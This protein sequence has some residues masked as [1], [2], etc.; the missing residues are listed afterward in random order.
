MDPD[1]HIY[2]RNPGASGI[3]T[4]IAWALPA[5][6]QPGSIHW[7]P[8]E[9]Y[10][11]GDLITYVYHD[12]VMLLVPL[13]LAKDLSPGRV[14]LRAR[15]SWLECKESCLPGS[16]ELA[17]SLRVGGELKPSAEHEAIEQ[18]RRRLPSEGS[19]LAFQGR[20]DM[21]AGAE[22]RRPVV[23]E[24]RDPVASSSRAEGASWDF[25]PYAA[26]D[27]E[28]QAATTALPAE[29][30]M[31][32]VR[33][34]VE[35]YHAD[36]WPD[37][38]E[39][40]VVLRKGREV[41]AWEVRGPVHEPGQTAAATGTARRSRAEPGWVRILAYAFLGGLILNVM[42]C[43]LPVIAL[44]ILG[45]VNQAREDRRRV[46]RLGLVYTLGVLVSFA[47][48]AALVIGLQA[49]GRQ[50]GWG[51]QFGNPYFLVAMTLLV[52]LIAL[53]LFGV[54][55]V[56][57]GGRALESAAGLARREGAAG[58]FFSGLLTTVLATSCTAPFLGAAV[59]FAF[60]QPPGVVVL[61]MLTIGAGLAFPY[62]LLSWQP[63]WMKWLP[64][65]G[66]WMEHFKVLMGFPMLAAGVWLL[67]L[68][69]AHY[70][71]RVWALGYFL[72]VVAVAAW[73]FGTFWQRSVRRHP[74][75]LWIALGLLV[76]GYATLLEGSM[77][78]RQ[79]APVT[80][81]TG[82]RAEQ[83]GIPWRSWSPEAVAEARRQ[84]H[85][86]LVDFTARW[87]LTCQVNK[88]FALEVD[89]VRQK[90]RE[91]GTVAFL[92]DY[93]HF[94]PAIGEELKRFGRA[95]VPLVV[96]YPADPSR[97]P[98]VLPEALT[99]GMVLEALEQAARN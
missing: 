61:V 59:G 70:G 7:P 45:F 4:E 29:E 12:E 79:P 46:R 82:P 34:E 73:L 2:W 66:P 25:Y 20:W 19:A 5:G 23:L 69:E 95:G 26:S 32:R 77:Q 64:K 60:V 85:P 27:Y 80:A 44:K 24:W 30:G 48:L 62:L 10:A 28:V 96:I 91:T 31:V 43:V 86:V 94:D 81:G 56:S 14:E 68:V 40:L 98:L 51:I 90:L 35:T 67:T 39:G 33:K 92:A 55:E 53:N 47:V 74:A 37:R 97:D 89:S 21:P 78:W 41:Q 15:V 72:V 9:K 63:A 71:E 6:V 65:P 13:H 8:P 3:A 88:K 99:P 75:A 52:T 22:R 50:A 76:G 42:P 83:D 57:L 49:A 93:T 18:W 17:A 1:W 54:F 16:A 11:E 84:G 36:R 58:A 87:C 38:L